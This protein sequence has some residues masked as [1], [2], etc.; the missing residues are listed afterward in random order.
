MP[1]DQRQ[2]KH[3]FIYWHLSRLLQNSIIASLGLLNKEFIFELSSV[4]QVVT[5]SS[6][7][8][9]PT[10]KGMY[11]VITGGVTVIEPIT[12]DYQPDSEDSDEEKH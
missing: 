8:K 1:Q 6:Y 12:L 4:I 3:Q 11:V 10:A 5:L 9:V 2:H 7:M